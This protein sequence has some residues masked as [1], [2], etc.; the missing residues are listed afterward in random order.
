MATSADPY[1]Y[2]GTGVLINRAGV[3]D[4]KLAKA[5]DYEQSA[6]R[7]KELS[8]VK[9]PERFDF[10]HIK[11]LHA[12]IF[13]D[14]YEWAG[15]PRT[16]DLSKGRTT[17]VRCQN[18]EAEGA[19]LGKSIADKGNLQGLGKNDFVKEITGVYAEL[20]TLHPFRE[21]NGRVTREF[22]SQLA[23]SAG[24]ALDQTRIDNSKDSWNKA[25]E[26]AAIGNLE[27][28][29]QIFASAIRPQR[30]IAFEQLPRDEALRQF[31]GLRPVYDSLDTAKKTLLTNYPGNE[32]AQSHFW[33]Q[34]VAEVQRKLDQGQGSLP[35]STSTQ[36]MRTGLIQAVPQ[37]QIQSQQKVVD[38]SKFKI[39]DSPA[40]AM[41]Q[42]QKVMSMRDACLAHQAAQMLNERPRE[43]MRQ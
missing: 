39:A 38:E 35:V 14:V 17:F 24:Y 30:A 23:G 1:V 27:P 21:G 15:Q 40:P 9:A 10:E 41:T 22:L 3:R 8:G 13:Q 34:A 11:K 28:S 26:Q 6:S 32:K 36:T 12:H 16:T 31:P 25:A 37:T 5:L 18:I 19:R 29:R 7:I 2:T 33:A 4:E 20:N 43:A 42:P